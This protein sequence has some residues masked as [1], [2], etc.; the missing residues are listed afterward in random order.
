MGLL[1]ASLNKPQSVAVRILCYE[2][3]GN[4]FLDTLS[5]K[6]QLLTVEFAVD[7]GSFFCAG[8]SRSSL[9]CDQY[10]TI[11]AVQ[12]NCIVLDKTHIVN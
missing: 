3:R 11:H 8:E 7:L 2:N 5:D 1:T 4:S 9:V 12:V 10:V 6:L